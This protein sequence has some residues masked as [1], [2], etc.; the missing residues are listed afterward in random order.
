MVA[1][2]TSVVV[3]HRRCREIT[4]T[5]PRLPFPAEAAMH[6]WILQLDK[7]SCV[8]RERFHEDRRQFAYEH[9]CG[10]SQIN[11]ALLKVRSI[12]FKFSL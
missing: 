12:E 8:N 3:R 10:T 7:T 5:D 9:H 4:E 2:S 6:V 11:Q 1:A